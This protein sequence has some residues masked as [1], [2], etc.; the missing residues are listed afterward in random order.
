[1]KKRICLLLSCILCLSLIACGDDES[2]MAAVTTQTPTE[3]QS[4]FDSIGNIDFT[5]NIDPVTID[6]TREFDFDLDIEVPTIHIEP[7]TVAPRDE[8]FFN[9]LIGDWEPLDIETFDAG[10]FIKK[11]QNNFSVSDQKTIESMD[12][13]KLLIIAEK[14]ANLLDD[15]AAAYKDSGISVQIDKTT[16]TITLDSSVLFATDSY[17][18]SAAGKELLKQFVQIYTGVIFHDTYSGFVS[19]IVIEG[20]TDTTGTYDYNMTLSQNR[21]DAVMTYLLSQEAGVDQETAA[22]LKDTMMA[23]GYS[24]DQPI[25]DANGKV[26][27]AASRRV[28][29]R[30]LIDIA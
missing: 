28:S 19:Q 11:S 23:V 26:D 24:Y 15:L 8:D 14:K 17:T 6:P 18:V 25:Y 4:P 29:F 5:V 20:H 7:I 16:G 9:N 2:S 13:E 30:F 3:S 1:M 10:D 21:A 12:K 22:L 27:L